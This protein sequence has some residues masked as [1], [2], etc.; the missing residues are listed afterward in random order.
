VIL[1]LPAPASA[2]AP[3]PTAGQG[4]WRLILIPLLLGVYFL[5][6]IV[7]AIRQHP[8]QAPLFLV[9]LFL[10]WTLVGWVVALAWAS[11]NYDRP[12]A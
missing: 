7:A 2:P 1:L 10:G 6:Y 11:W 5:P 3:L 9:N 8:Q 12:V 4:T